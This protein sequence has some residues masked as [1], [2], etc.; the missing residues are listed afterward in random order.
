MKEACS[1]VLALGAALGA[2]VA[3]PESPAPVAL[4]APPCVRVPEARAEEPAD[5]ELGV[6]RAGEYCAYP[7]RM[8]AYHRI[9]NDH[10]GGP[11]IL[12][13]YDPD[14]GAGRVFDPV[15]EGRAYTFDVA[16]PQRGLPALKDRETGSMWS[17]LTGE[18]LMGPL[19]GKRMALIPSLILTWEHWKSLH[20]DSWVLAEDAKLSAH[21]TARVTAPSCPIPPALSRQ[22]PRRADSRLKPDMLVLGLTNAGEAAAFPLTAEAGRTQHGPEVIEK[23]VGGRPVVLFSDP[24]ARAAAAYEPVVK[25]RPLTFAVRG[26]GSAPGWSDRQTG[27]IWTIDGRCVEGSLKGESLPP[28]DFVRIR[29][30]AWSAL[31]PGSEI[32]R[33]RS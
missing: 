12:V 5:E 8:M 16:P 33:S 29:W 14:S 3:A 32:V 22:L 31:H 2:A 15:L 21:Y 13:S 27:S 9:V 18:A 26:E 4:N 1:L 6:G 23:R 30:Y 20:P 25:D 24:A 28:V 7:L 17:A 19:A 10:L 11:P